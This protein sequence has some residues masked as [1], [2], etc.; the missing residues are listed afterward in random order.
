MERVYLYQGE[1]YIGEANNRAQW[2]YNECAVERTEA[3]E[4]A[5]LHQHKRLAKFDAAVAEYRRGIPELA[6]PVNAE[7]LETPV[8]LVLEQNEQ[9]KNYEDTDTTDYAALAIDNL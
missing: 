8:E 7:V 3:D 6:T 9:P 1:T 5:M 4:A 2:A